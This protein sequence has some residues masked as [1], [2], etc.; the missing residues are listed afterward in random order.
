MKTL[1]LLLAAALLSALPLYSQTAKVIALDAADTAQAKSLD[2][3]LKALTEKREV[4]RR[5]IIE[6][7]LVTSDRAS[8]NEYYAE[9]SLTTLTVS[10]GNFITCG[11]GSPTCSIV[12]PPE[13]AEEKKARKEREAKRRWYRAGWGAYGKY[14]FTDDYRYIVPVKDELPTAFRT[15]NGNLPACA[16]AF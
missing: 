7:Y 12:L 4:F 8:G 16:V 10:S 1:R 9:A 3:Q 15:L 2:D 5:S 11:I 13:T 14:E 6:K